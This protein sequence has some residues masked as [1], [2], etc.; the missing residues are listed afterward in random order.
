M[1]NKIIGVMG[2]GFGSTEKENRDAFELGQLIAKEGWILLSGGRNVGVMDYASKGAKEAGGLT[3]GVMP[4]ADPTIISDAIDIPIITN[5]SS[6]RNNI[7]VLS[8]DVIIACGTSLGTITEIAFALIEKKKVILIN[9][10]DECVEL[11]KKLGKENINVVNT[12]K[13]A[14]KLVKKIFE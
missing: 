4:T 13:E 3:I 14:I 2:P 11:F 5:I 7:N 8:S 12:P 10:F 9:Q 6:A 1:R